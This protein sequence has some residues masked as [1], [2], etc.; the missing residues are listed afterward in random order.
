MEQCTYGYQTVLIGIVEYPVVSTST[1]ATVEDPAAVVNV[2][3]ALMILQLIFLVAI[4]C[5]VLWQRS[6]IRS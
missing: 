5:C 6:S 2:T 1:C 4:F 3:H